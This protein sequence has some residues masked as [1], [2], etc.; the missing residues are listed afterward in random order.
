MKKLTLTL[1]LLCA[2]NVSAQDTTRT[3]RE[4]VYINYKGKQM[5]EKQVRRRIAWERISFGL[6]MVAATCIIIKVK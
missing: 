3:K 6:W 5:T 1:T 2:L 4:T